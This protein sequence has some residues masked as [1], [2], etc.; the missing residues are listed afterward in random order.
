[1][2]AELWR[3]LKACGFAGSLRVV[4][5]EST[6]RRRDGKLGLASRALLS[7]R[8]IARSMTT[9]RETGSAATALINAVV[10]KAVSTLIAAR[11]VLERFHAM[12]RSKSEARLDPWI[13]TAAKTKLAAFASGVDADRDA[14]A[15]AISTPWP[16][17]QVEGTICRLK[18]INRQMYGRAKLDLRKARMMVP[19]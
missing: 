14:V 1:M 18:S 3:R 19:A 13:A 10:E 15:A 17:G 12:M 2:G 5:E 16:S 7:T 9:E 6:R 4:S 11:E 8:I